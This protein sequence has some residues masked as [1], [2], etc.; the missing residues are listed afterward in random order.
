MSK[1]VHQYGPATM[2][3]VGS[4]DV[5]GLT[6]EAAQQGIFADLLIRSLIRVE[7][8]KVD[9]DNEDTINKKARENGGFDGNNIGNTYRQPSELLKR[10]LN[11]VPVNSKKLSKITL[12]KAENNTIKWK[13][14]YETSL[15]A[16]AETSAEIID[17]IFN[18][19][20]LIE[21]YL[22]SFIMEGKILPVKDA[23]IKSIIEDLLA[24]LLANNSRKALKVKWDNHL[25]RANIMHPPARSDIVK[26]FGSMS[27]P[28]LLL[29][30]D[31][32]TRVREGNLYDLAA[33]D[34]GIVWNATHP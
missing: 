13:K 24:E 1:L 22:T 4:V 28:T 7:I 23:N 26:F 19:E 3:F 10:Y 34:F 5:Y 30:L 15:N 29:T 31:R 8:N 25:D 21:E 2:K 6:S 17:N 20:T 27:H 18:T 14:I 32:V 9:A 33:D 16:A 11:D 12:N